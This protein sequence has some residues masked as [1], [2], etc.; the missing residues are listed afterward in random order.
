[1]ITSQNDET[2]THYVL[3]E[4]KN[5]GNV[6]QINDKTISNYHEMFILYYYL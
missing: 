1:M 2:K 5:V 3:N 4:N 6:N